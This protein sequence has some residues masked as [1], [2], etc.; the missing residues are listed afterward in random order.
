MK[1]G[2]VAAG[3]ALA[4]HSLA[5]PAAS[6]GPATPGFDRLVEQFTAAW[7]AKD[8]DRLDELIEPSIGLWVIRSIGVVREPRSFRSV[9]E[10]LAE[11]EH[12]FG[13]LDAAGFGG[14]DPKPGPVPQ[15]EDE[16]VML[17]LCRFGTAE[18]AFLSVFDDRDWPAS[19]T[20][21]QLEHERALAEAV[22]G[23]QVFF[24]SDQHW[25]AAFYFVRADQGWT[26]LV[27]DMSDCAA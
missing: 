19:P 25:G 21:E 14:C 18:P 22:E 6:D 16:G 3:A 7:D 17:P 23:R 1:K 8:L 13:Y 2:L 15:C 26:L 4:L 9:E 20:P 5:P 27:I 12:G 11:G 24:L 10:A